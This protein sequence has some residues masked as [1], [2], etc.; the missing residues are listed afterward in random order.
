MTEKKFMQCA[1]DL[2]LKGNPSP[3]PFVGCVIVKEGEIVGEGFHEKFG[4]AHAEI[5]ALNKVGEKSRDAVMYV[6][7]EPCNHY[8]KTPPCTKKII[9]AG[10]KKVV[11]AMQDPNPLVNG[12]G[13]QALKKA[14]IEVNLGLMEE[15]ARKLNE[16]Y[17]KFQSKRKPFV[18]LKAA[19]SLDGRIATKEFNS[20]WISSEESRKKVHELRSK[21]DAI[22]VG[23]NTVLKDNPKLTSRIEGGRNPLRVIVTT[24]KISS[25]YNVFNDSNFLIATTKKENFS[26]K[27][28]EGKVLELKKENNLVDLKTLLYLLAERKVSNVLVEGGSQI[29]TSFLKEKLADKLMLFISPKILGND[30]I[31]VFGSL[32]IKKVKEGVE[33]INPTFTKIGKDVLFTADLKSV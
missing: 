30:S 9:D 18:I 8:G 13:I 17:I 33:L 31:P 5:N 4:E 28:F 2:S 21:I 25:N 14:G 23:G 15:E 1:L 27:K 20:K 16:V 26:G 3:N 7:L 22:L 24:K 6:S 12:K 19:V 11:I 29:L 10:I 32:E